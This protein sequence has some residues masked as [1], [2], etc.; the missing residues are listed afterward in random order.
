MQFNGLRSYILENEFKVTVLNNRVNIVNYKELGHFDSNKVIVR[1]MNNNCNHNLIVKGCNL[2][3]SK[4][5]RCEVLIVGRIDN[6]EF[7]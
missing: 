6:I 5:K 3:V 2:V 4:L 7:R 1:Y